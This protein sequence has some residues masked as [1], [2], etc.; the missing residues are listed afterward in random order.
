MYSLP[1]LHRAL[2]R[3]L[4]VV[5]VSLPIA[6]KPGSS[7]LVTSMSRLKPLDVRSSC[8]SLEM[9][10]PLSCACLV[11]HTS[12]F[13]KPK[14]HVMTLKMDLRCHWISDYLPSIDKLKNSGCRLF[15]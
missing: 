5:L 9:S 12:F 11:I 7:R 4:A 15:A 3:K 2:Y 1:L 14:L 10:R 13:L 8:Q 6:G